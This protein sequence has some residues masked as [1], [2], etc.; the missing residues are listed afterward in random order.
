MFLGCWVTRQS[1]TPNLRPSITHSRKTWVDWFAFASTR[2]A[3]SIAIM[4]CWGTVS[5]C[6][7]V[8][9]LWAFRIARVIVESAKSS[10]RSPT[11]GMSI[12]TTLFWARSS[13]MAGI[14]EP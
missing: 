7:S 2:C 6:E 14:E 11:P 3:S 1:P 9:C 12:S 4:T 5:S 8:R 13:R 10:P